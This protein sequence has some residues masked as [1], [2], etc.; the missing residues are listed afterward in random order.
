MI[1]AFNVATVGVKMEHV[2]CIKQQ[3]EKSDVFL[4]VLCGW[5]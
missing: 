3:H 2:I 4:L 5:K 1:H